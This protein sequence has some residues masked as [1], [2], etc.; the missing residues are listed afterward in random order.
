MFVIQMYSILGGGALDRISFDKMTIKEQVDYINSKLKEKLSLRMISEEIGIQRKSIRL[1][2]RKN[3]YEFDKKNNEYIY[4]TNV[5]EGEDTDKSKAEYKCNTNVVEDKKSGAAKENT[6]VFKTEKKE[7]KKDEYKH[8]TNVF[9]KVPTKEIE[10]YKHNTIVFDG[11]VKQDL[12]SLAEVKEDIFK[13]IQ[14]FNK[15][16]KEENI[17]DLPELKIDKTKFKD[18]VKVTTVRLYSNIKEEFK[19]FAEKYPEYKS[20]DLYSQAL[21]EFMQKYKK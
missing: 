1:R 6:N 13:I 5:F 4:N 8:N 18:D 19:K 2:F 20:Q 14:W 16:K 9:E 15:E 7:K 21:L 17:I 10:K 3:G 11:S 12:L